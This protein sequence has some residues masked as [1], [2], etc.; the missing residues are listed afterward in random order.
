MSPA[1]HEKF[2]NRQCKGQT[3]DHGPITRPETLRLKCPAGTRH[4]SL[5]INVK[6]V[7]T[8][9]WAMQKHLFGGL[10]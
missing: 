9:M 6:Y 1:E 4:N 10:C 8:T 3:Q 5:H 7:A 2:V